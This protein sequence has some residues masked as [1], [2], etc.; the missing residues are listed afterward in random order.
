MEESETSLLAC[1]GSALSQPSR[2]A[3]GSC[4]QSPATCP[5]ISIGHKVLIRIE[6]TLSIA[7]WLRLWLFQRQQNASAEDASQTT[8]ACIHVD[9]D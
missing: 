5:R 3:D 9:K 6:D 7:V 1:A 4:G 2:P 8:M